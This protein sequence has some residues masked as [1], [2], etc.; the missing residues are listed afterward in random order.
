MRPS[1]LAGMGEP[2]QGAALHDEP[3]ACGSGIVSP[4][5]APSPTPAPASLA[6][7][8]HVTL[9]A[10]QDDH[11]PLSHVR[12]RVPCL[13]HGSL[14]APTQVLPAH[15]PHWQLPPQ[16]CVRPGAHS[17]EV[18]GAQTP[19]LLHADQTDQRPLLHVRVCVPQF[20]QD[21]VAGPSHVWF[22]HVP[23]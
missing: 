11:R 6:G 21:C 13:Q 3:P 17:C 22:T 4:S 8:A 18:F 9:Q 5:L 23:H 16:V 19:S 15:S 10:D 1:K 12:V 7:S 14:V 20:P 2:P